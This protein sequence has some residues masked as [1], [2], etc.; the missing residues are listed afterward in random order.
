MRAL[1]IRPTVRL[2]MA[3]VAISA[4]TLFGFTWRLRDVRDDYRQ[5]A[6]YHVA[7]EETE[8]KQVLGMAKLREKG[9]GNDQRFQLIERLA[10]LRLKYHTEMRQKYES[11]AE[12]PWESVPADPPEPRDERLITGSLDSLG[13]LRPIDGS[14]L[15]LIAIKKEVRRADPPSDSK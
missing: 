4:V 12:H 3:I 9:Y 10:G 7:H 15:K 8:K 2:L 14:G 6:L 11:A 1:R 5:A 13:P